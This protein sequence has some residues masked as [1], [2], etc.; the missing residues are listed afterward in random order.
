MINPYHPYDIT[1]EK[2]KELALGKKNLNI[3]SSGGQNII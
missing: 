1:S 3:D 2:I